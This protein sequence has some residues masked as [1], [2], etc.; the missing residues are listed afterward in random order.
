MSAVAEERL[1]ALEARLARIERALPEDRVTIIAF[2]RDFDKV[3]TS[4]LLAT[5]AAAMGSEVSMF[6][7]FW[8]LTVL[9]KGTRLR[10]K[11][12]TEKL[13]ATM[14][15]AGAGGTSSLNMLGVGPAFFRFLMKKKKVA[16]LETLI[17]QARELGVRFVAC[18]MSM[19]V[20]G[21]G[22]DELLAD[23]EIGGA[24]TCLGDA[25]KSRTTLF[26]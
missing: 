4:F 5:A 19:D 1:A 8:G 21:I 17:E 25:G 16:S 20:M 7:A 3:L 10:K 13:L 6:F 9:K 26:V 2:S 24:V 23:V 11:P 22:R 14:L 15:P 12:V 18:S